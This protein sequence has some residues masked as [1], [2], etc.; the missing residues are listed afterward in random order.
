MSRPSL[1]VTHGRFVREVDRLIGYKVDSESLES[2]YQYMIGEMIMLRLFSAMEDAISEIAFKLAANA[3]YTNGSHTNLLAYSGSVVRSRQLLLTYGRPRPANYLKWTKAAFVRQ[4]V[5][6]VFPEAEPYSKNII[7]HSINLNNMR[8]VRNVLAHQTSS[9]KLDY[10]NL[11][12]SEYGANVNVS[13]GAFLISTNRTTPCNLVKY[14]RSSKV[15]VA[16][17]ASG[18]SV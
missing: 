4:S 12:R 10:R 1:A 16:D 18:R 13:T 6:F 5:K 8:I 11:I 9:A 14:L 17:V 7:N 2:K 15:L 3:V